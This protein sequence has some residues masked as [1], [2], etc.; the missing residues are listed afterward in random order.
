MINQAVEEVFLDLLPIMPWQFT[1][2]KLISLVANQDNYSLAATKTATTIAF[3]NSNPDTITD[4]GNGFLTAG[5]EAGMSITISGA[6]NAGNNSTFR[7]VTVA[8]G[9][10][11]LDIADSLTAEAAGA[12][13]TIT[14]DDPFWQIDKVERNVTDENPEEIEIIDPLEAQFYH[15]VDETEE[16]PRRCFFLGNTLYFRPIPS[17]A[18]TNYVKIYMTRREPI[19]MPTNGPAYIPSPAHRLIIYRA[20]ELIGTILEANITSF[21]IL[22]ARRFE[23]IRKVWKTRYQTKPRFIRESITERARLDTRERAFTDPSWRT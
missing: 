23:G 10:L 4:S 1:K 12:S 9:T 5:F 21:Q 13:V 20:C 22:Y 11:T 15:Y 14:Q 6:T 3:I 2:T 17:A 16:N 8:A 19:T 18:K 7:I